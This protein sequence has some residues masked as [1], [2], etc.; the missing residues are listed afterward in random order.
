MRCIAAGAWSMMFCVCAYCYTRHFITDSISKN[1]E[2]RCSISA[3]CR[4]KEAEGEVKKVGEERSVW[5]TGIIDWT[6]WKAVGGRL[7]VC[8]ATPS[9]NFHFLSAVW[10]S[11]PSRGESDSKEV[12][13]DWPP[14]MCPSTPLISASIESEQMALWPRSPSP[15]TIIIG[16]E[17]MM[18]LAQ[19]PEGWCRDNLSRLWK[20][21]Y[22]VCL[23]IRQQL[24][25]VVCELVETP[26]P[27]YWPRKVMRA[28][29]SLPSKG[30]RAWFCLVLCFIL[31]LL[32]AVDVIWN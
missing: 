25:Y 6:A 9:I 1:L 27:V 5:R 22:F 7:S 26:A 17:R 19:T 8:A 14:D 24:T 32:A 29:E 21:I 3:G 30:C 18:R 11:K 20:Q 4:E 31:K 12:S 2:C 28:T 10:C 16:Q 23:C 15:Y 13:P